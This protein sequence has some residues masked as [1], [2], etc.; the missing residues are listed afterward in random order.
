MTERIE[1]VPCAAADTD[2]IAATV[3]GLYRAGAAGKRRRVDEC[4]WN[5]CESDEACVVILV[6]DIVD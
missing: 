4:A 2:A 6:P 1:T 3:H 5:V